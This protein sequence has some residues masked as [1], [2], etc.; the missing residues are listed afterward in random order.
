MAKRLEEIIKN[1]GAKG[2]KNENIKLKSE[3]TISEDYLKVTIHVEV[4]Y[5]E[6]IE[7]ITINEEKI[8]VL[9]KNNGVYIVEKEVDRNGIYIIVAKDKDG[10][11]N[12]TTVKVSEILG[13]MEIW[14][15]ED[16]EL[17]RQRVNEGKIFVSTKV[18]VM[19]D[20]DLGGENWEPIGTA[21]RPFLGE[22]EGNNKKIKGLYIEGAGTSTGLFRYNNG[23][24]KDIEIEN[25]YVT[26]TYANTGMLVGTNDGKIEN[27]KTSGEIYGE[28]KTGGVVGESRT[29]SSIT[30]CINRANINK[31]K[32]TFTLN[33]N[34]TGRDS[35]IQ[36]WSS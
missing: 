20:I 35:R 17:L 2:N 6:D 31:D 13:D 24:I 32:T 29:G 28:N 7:S 36:L 19:N 33:S 9:E 5:G 3:K 34:L 16:M 11:Y 25:G 12:I 18:R 1:I 4:E 15:K 23:T 14:D 22:L 26:S 21:E 8:E 10:N 30:G 27:I